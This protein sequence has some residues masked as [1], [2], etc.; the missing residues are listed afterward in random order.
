MK[1]YNVV[2]TKCDISQIMTFSDFEAARDCFVEKIFELDDDNHLDEVNDIN[3]DFY[4]KN[5][6]FKDLNGEYVIEI[7]IS[8]LNV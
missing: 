4:V 8:E 5:Q 3:I 1:L 2:I 6:Y 7:V